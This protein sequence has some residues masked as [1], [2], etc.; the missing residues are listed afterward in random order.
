MGL[1]VKWNIL[2]LLEDNIDE[3]LSGLGLWYDFWDKMV[4]VQF[5]KEK[6][7]K[8]D[9]IEMKNLHS[10]ENTAKRMKRQVTDW[11]NV[12]NKTHVC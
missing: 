11:E 7:E 1:T 5:M 10:E 3:N 8:L 6:N 12:F 9:L 2:K 4:K